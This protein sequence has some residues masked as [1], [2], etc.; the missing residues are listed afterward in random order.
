MKKKL[1]RAFTLLNQI[2]VLGNQVDVMYEIRLLLSE[3]YQ[4]LPEEKEKKDG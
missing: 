4:S 3:V 1:A 2:P